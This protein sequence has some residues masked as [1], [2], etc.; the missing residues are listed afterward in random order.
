MKRTKILHHIPPYQQMKNFLYC[1]LGCGVV[2]FLF[3]NSLVASVILMPLSL[4]AYRHLNTI[5]KHRERLMIASQF[6]DLLISISTSLAMGRHMVEALRTGEEAVSLIHGTQSHLS[7]RLSTILKRAEESNTPIDSLLHELA[8]NTDLEEMKSFVD[9]YAVSRKTGGNVD[10][11]IR[12]TAEIL[13]ERMQLDQSIRILT[14][15]KRMEARIL[16]SMP[17]IILLF[18]RLTSS[19]YMEILYTSLAGRLVMSIS[20]VA[21]LIAYLWSDKL[22]RVEF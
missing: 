8:E 1:V 18:V 11:I 2:G 14:A 3:Y 13:L 15:Q 6:R 4:P 7:Q 12:K 21:I 17:F 20:F 9:I 5:R 16:S 19:E 10:R 22:T